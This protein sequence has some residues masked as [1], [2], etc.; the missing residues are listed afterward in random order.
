MKLKVKNKANSENRDMSSDENLSQNGS[1]TARGSNPDP[2]QRSVIGAGCGGNVNGTGDPTRRDVPTGAAVPAIRSLDAGL[3][4]GRTRHL[5]RKTTKVAERSQSPHR[6]NILMRIDLN[7]L[8][9]CHGGEEGTQFFAA[10][11]AR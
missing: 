1:E 11:A 6:R 8:L 5:A 2:R 10:S 7:A 9:G 4:A 3:A